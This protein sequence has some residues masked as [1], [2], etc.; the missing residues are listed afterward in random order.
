MTGFWPRVVEA[1]PWCLE[2]SERRPVLGL[3]E[4]CKMLSSMSAGPH[5]FRWQGVV[6][7]P[8][9]HYQMWD[10]RLAVGAATEGCKH[11]V[12]CL[13]ACHRDHPSCHRSCHRSQ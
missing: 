6:V 9:R 1:W 10:V 5:L 11:S 3:L 8:P 7:P 2:L 4:K 13:S 12:K